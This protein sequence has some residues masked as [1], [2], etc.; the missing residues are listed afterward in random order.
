MLVVHVDD[1]VGCATAAFGS[2]IIE[3]VKTVFKTSRECDS[4]FRYISGLGIKRERNR[5]VMEQ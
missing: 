5:I 4:M 2:N 1:F 3:A